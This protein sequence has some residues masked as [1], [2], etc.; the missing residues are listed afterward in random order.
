MTALRTVVREHLADADSAADVVAVVVFA[1]IAWFL[2]W[3]LR[4]ELED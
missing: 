2:L 3:A 1:P 4:D